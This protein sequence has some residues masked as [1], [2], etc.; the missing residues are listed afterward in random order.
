VGG[1]KDGPSVAALSAWAAS[2]CGTLV[3]RA[4]A[5]AC[6][7]EKSGALTD[8][9]TRPVTRRV[10]FGGGGGLE[11]ESD[12]SGGHSSGSRSASSSIE[13]LRSAKRTVTCL[14]SPSSAALE[15]RIF[16]AR[17]FGVYDCGELDF[18][19]ARGVDGTSDLPQP[20]QNLSLPSF[21]KP[22][23]GHVEAKDSPHSPQKRRPSRF[24]AW[25]RGHCMPGPPSKLGWEQSDRW[26][27]LSWLGGPG[28]EVPKPARGVPAKYSAACWRVSSLGPAGA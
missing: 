3:S 12:S 22:H 18:G 6:S 19:S 4:V 8:K 2:C 21:R 27:E 25:H 24:S 5:R 9:L 20:P 13:P 11:G 15:V 10:I 14:R 17:C 16:S 7:R 1:V 26:R 28:Q 23:D